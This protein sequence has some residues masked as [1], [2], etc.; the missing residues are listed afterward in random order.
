MENRQK[1]YSQTLFTL[2]NTAKIQDIVLLFW[3]FKGVHLT[4][5]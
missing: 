2:I 5:F 4:L 1:K 3:D